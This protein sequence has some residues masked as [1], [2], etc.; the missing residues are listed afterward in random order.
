[1]ALSVLLL[2][3]LTGCTTSTTTLKTEDLLQ[4]NLGAKRRLLFLVSSGYVC[5]LVQGRVWPGHTAAYHHRPFSYFT[6]HREADAQLE[7]DAE[8]AAE[9]C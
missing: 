9:A 5:N 7:G 3:V 1:M 2:V 8:A 6:A 4:G